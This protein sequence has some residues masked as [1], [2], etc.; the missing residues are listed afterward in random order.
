MKRGS[1]MDRAGALKEAVRQETER[2][3]LHEPEEVRALRLGLVASGAGVYGQV[4]SVIV[5]L[6]GEARN[7]AIHGFSNLVSFA[8][9]GRFDL[10]QLRYLTRET[11]RVTAG[12]IGYFG[13][14]RLGGLLGEFLAC[15]DE[16]D[17]TETMKALLEEFFTLSNRYQMWLHQTFPWH[18]A[19]HFPRRSPQELEEALELARR[20]EDTPPG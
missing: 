7:L 13:L 1:V 12:V 18:L 19:V 9:S 20:L 17:D 11:L 5:M 8:A 2:I 16:I 4:F 15:L 6:G 3:W 10:D 14:K